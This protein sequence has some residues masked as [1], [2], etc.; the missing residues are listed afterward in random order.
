MAEGV[1]LVRTKDGVIVYGNQTFEHMFGYDAGELVGKHVS[2]VNAPSQKDPEEIANEIIETL[3]GKGVWQG[4]VLNIRK[5]GSVFWCFANVSAFEHSQYGNVWVSVQQDISERKLAEF[6]LRDTLAEAQ[7][8][9]KALDSVSSYV[10]MKDTQSRYVYANRLTLE[11]F[12]SSSKELVGCDDTCF[13]P[14]ETVKR[15]REIDLRVFAGEE[16]FEEIDVANMGA[17]RRIYWEIKTPIYADAERKTIWGL[18]GISTDITERKKMVE[19]REKLIGELKA[20]L[21]NIK[22]LS[23]MLPICA[24][25]KKIRDDK[26]YWEE[27]ATYITKHSD[28]LFSHGICPDCAKKVYEELNKLKDTR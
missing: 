19:E 8:F 16:T 1:L 2:I 14:P 17:G 15:L 28:T 21:A 13:F 9:R 10:Y 12:G 27:V 24:Y 22:T 26:G 23:G 20:A 4:E 11:L 6:K 5:D 25:C 18:L 7:R 3:Q